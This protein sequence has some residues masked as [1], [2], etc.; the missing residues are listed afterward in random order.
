MIDLATCLTD[1]CELT[2]SPSLPS[3]ATVASRYSFAAASMA[4][5]TLAIAVG[6]CSAHCICDV[7][8]TRTRTAETA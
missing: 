1:I 5:C 7:L 3:V 4:S 2:L 6:C 8:T